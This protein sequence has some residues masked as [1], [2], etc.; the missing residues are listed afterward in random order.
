MLMR[1]CAD[2]NLKTGESG[3]STFKHPI[4]VEDDNGDAAVQW[5]AFSGNSQGHYN[6]VQNQLYSMITNFQSLPVSYV[7]FTGHEKKYKE[8][9]APMA[10]YGVSVPGNAITPLVPTWLGDCIHAQDY[11]VPVTVKVPDASVESGFVEE[12]TV[13]VRCRYYFVKHPDPDTGLIFDA[14]PRVTHSKVAELEKAFP[15]GFF[16]PTTE[17]GF[18]Q[19]LR[20]VDKLAEDAAQSDS[21][22][23]WRERADQKLGRAIAAPVSK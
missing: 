23:N 6:F 21:L 17:T 1:H 22:K 19:Y 13:R 10:Q 15:G 5:E 11:K 14:K 16:T 4:L 8:D 3:T 9:G 18:D 7:L 12:Q 20:V 2:K